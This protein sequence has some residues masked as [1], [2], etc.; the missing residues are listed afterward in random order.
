MILT[1]ENYT[2][3]DK[4]LEF[5]ENRGVK[6]HAQP[7]MFKQRSVYGRYFDDSMQQLVLS[8]E[9]IRGA[10][11]RMAEWKKEGRQLIFSA[12]TYQKAAAWEDY[13]T[14]TIQGEEPSA[15]MAGK[16]YI[17]IE[18]NGDVHPCGLNESLFS[19][20]NIIESGLEAA[21]IHARRHHCKDCWM[22]YMNERKRVFG[23]NPDALWEIIRRG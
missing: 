21:I 1:C 9:Q 3:L 18:P 14:A 15:C 16:Y 5:C 8:D 4:M 22:V 13:S 2:D 23:L 20:K 19:P 12:S 6:M 17:H 7:A 10:H 11:K